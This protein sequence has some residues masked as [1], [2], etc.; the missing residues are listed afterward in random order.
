MTV[1][2][3]NVEAI[4]VQRCGRLMSFVGMAVTVAGSNASLND[5]IGYALRQSGYSVANISSVA[6]LDLASVAADDLD[7]VLDYAE[8]RTLESVA[9][10]MDAVDIANGPEKE[11]FSQAAT[12]VDKRIAKLSEKITLTYGSSVEAEVGNMVFDFAAHGDDSEL[13]IQI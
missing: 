9:G 8:L 12:A 6:D 5:P 10:N 2:R 7:M 11:N 13:D 1:T 4:L 3:A